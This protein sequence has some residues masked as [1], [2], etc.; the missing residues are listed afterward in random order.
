VAETKDEPELRRAKAQR[1]VAWCNMV[2]QKA[3]WT[4]GDTTPGGGVFIALELAEQAH[5]AHS[6]PY[7]PGLSNMQLYDPRRFTWVCDPAGEAQDCVKVRDERTGHLVPWP[8][9]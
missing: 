4:K 9:F 7:E 1:Y 6:L 8:W 3:P 2:V 5:K